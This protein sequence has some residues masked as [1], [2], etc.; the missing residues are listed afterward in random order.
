MKFS[1]FKTVEK[2]FPLILVITCVAV[3]RLVDS[4]TIVISIFASTLIVYAVRRYNPKILVG[5][6]LFLL[7]V[8]AVELAL[9]IKADAEQIAI[10]AYYFLAIGVIGELIELMRRRNEKEQASKD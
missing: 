1:K 8:C 2:L 3:G 4:L 10:L 7:I 5:I 6:A 9:M